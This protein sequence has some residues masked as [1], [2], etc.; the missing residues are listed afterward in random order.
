V[1]TTTLVAVLL[2]FDL[3]TRLPASPAYGTSGFR[4]AQTQDPL[5]VLTANAMLLATLTL[6][7]AAPWL[8]RSR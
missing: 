3:L 1:P 5:V 8:L 4:L 6:F 7:L 2:G